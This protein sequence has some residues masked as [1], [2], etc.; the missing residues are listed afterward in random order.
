MCSEFFRIP[1]SAGGVPIFGFGVLLLVWLAATGWSIWGSARQFGAAAAIQAHLPTLLIG[2]AVIVFLPRMFPDGVPIR[3]YGV[4]VVT[5]SAAGIALAVRRAKQNGVDPDEIFG[6]AIAMFVAGIVGARLF[7]LIE[8]WDT[9]IRRSVPGSDAMDWG[10]TLREALSF[11]EGGLVVYGSLIGAL[12]AF[13]WYMRRRGLPMLA[14]ADLIAPSMAIGLAFGRIGC[15]L[16]GCCYG[17]ETTAPWA[18]TFPRENAPGRTSPPYGVQA[19]HGRMYGLRLAGGGV[20]YGDN[21]NDEAT[22]NGPPTVVAVDDGSAA[23]NAGVQ[24]GDAIA[25]INGRATRTLDA[26]YDALFTA[27]VE[28]ADVTL[29]TAGGATRRIAAVDPPP[30]SLPVHPT[31][32]YSAVN[33]TLLFAVLW[34][35]FPLRRR[36]GAVIALTLTLYPIARFL[37]EII[38]VD[39]SAV[40]GT[41]LSISQNVSIAMLALAAG[42]WLWL[43]RQPPGELA[44]PLKSGEPSGGAAA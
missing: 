27:F 25:M 43:W 31:Q 4:M 8:Y 42:L 32:I 41:G 24:T 44:L 35:F 16:N 37:L 13:G 19:Q 5:G 23:D 36:D 9:N 21:A 38:R 29:R 10:A 12:L 1:I 3:G 33:A 34:T 26:A 30:R 40:F 11:T 17:G 15:L 6:L 39:E 18:V 14:M 2:A 22:D 20:D 28:H 7:F